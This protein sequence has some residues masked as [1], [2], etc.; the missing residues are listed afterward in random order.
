LSFTQT[1]TFST[2]PWN[3]EGADDIASLAFEFGLDGSGDSNSGN[4]TQL[5]SDS[6]V[7]SLDQDGFSVGHLVSLQVKTDGSIVG[8]YDNGQDITLGM[9]AVATFDS[10]TG[11]ER[12]GSNSFRATRTPGEPT[13]GVPGEG[14][15][16]DIFGSS[17]EASNVDIEDEFVN[18]ITAQRSY[19]ANSRVM[20]ATNELLR[21]LVNLV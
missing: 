16:G 4:I 11:L 5:S 14:G 21:E 13:F 15:R 7:T 1:D 9:V 3:F 20:S 8:R 2:T 19:Q 17:L 6:T 12:M 10:T 18:M